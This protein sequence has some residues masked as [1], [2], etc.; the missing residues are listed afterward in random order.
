MRGAELHTNGPGKEHNVTITDHV[1]DAS[2]CKLCA[3]M[4]IQFYSK[5]P[6]FEARLRAGYELSSRLHG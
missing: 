4:A 5:G 6:V 3:F 1:T 2:H